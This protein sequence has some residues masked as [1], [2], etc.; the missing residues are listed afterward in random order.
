M[1]ITLIP[2]IKVE[3]T[4][5]T[6]EQS[7]AP[8]PVLEGG[9][10]TFAGLCQS[11]PGQHD[12]ARAEQPD[13]TR[14]NPGA[15]T[16]TELRAQALCAAMVPFQAQNPAEM[17]E[18]LQEGQVFAGGD[19][20]LPLTEE[21]SEAENS[22]EGV[23]PMMLPAMESNKSLDEGGP[24]HTD[25]AQEEQ[26]VVRPFRET[27]ADRREEQVTPEAG[28][29]ASS[30]PEP[31][32]D[33][34]S[35]APR[36]TFQQHVQRSAST[37][38]TA[39]SS[40]PRMLRSLPDPEALSLAVMRQ[41]AGSVRTFLAQGG[42]HRMVL[43]LVPET[44]GRVVMHMDIDPDRKV[45][46]HVQAS[47]PEALGILRAHTVT[48]QDLLRD[49]GLVAEG[50]DMT[51]TWQQTPDDSLFRQDAPGVVR[52]E[53]EGGT[54]AGPQRIP[55]DVLAHEFLGRYDWVV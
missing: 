51:M 2:T 55:A 11:A 37:G 1:K 23:P 9:G 14:E 10:R 12:D 27:G 42:H 54:T 29:S 44:L 32:R 53:E 24:V 22:G 6:A 46:L 30:S 7:G 45:T 28:D 49:S 33:L 18:R 3:T 35:G 36:D 26:S 5:P 48:L 21:G 20:V 39:G 8:F 50:G 34:S 52:R 16:D 25:P 4:T 13:E 17:H 47:S 38:S 15:E 40:E 19:G 41:T 43:D 31:V